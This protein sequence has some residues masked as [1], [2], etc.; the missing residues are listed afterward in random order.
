MLFSDFALPPQVLKALEQ[1]GYNE[2]TPIQA[3]ALPIVLEG[4]DLIGSAQ[5]GTGKT[6]AFVLPALA[7]LAEFKQPRPRGPR[8]LVLAPT[9][10]LA[11]QILDAT[12]KLGK[13]MRLNTV[14][15]LGGMPY[16]LQLQLLSRPVDLMVATPG[17][18]I[19][20]LERGR[21]SLADLEMLVLDEADR[22][23]DMGFVDAV[24]TIVA[25]SPATRQTLLFTA[26]FDKR[27]VQLTQ[28]ML[29]DPARVAIEAETLTVDRIEQRLHVAD[30]LGHKRR[31]LAHLAASP[32]VE[33]AIIFAATKRDADA[34]A[35]ELNAQGHQASALHGDMTQSARNYTVQKLKQGRIRLLVATDVAARGIDVKDLTHV[36]NFDLPRQAEDYVHRIGRTGRAGASGIAISFASPAD[37]QLVDRIERYTGA[38]LAPHV[39]PGLEPT[40]SFSKRSG[41]RKQGSYQNGPRR[42]GGPGGSHAGRNEGS[43][44]YR[45][46]SGGQGHYQG[47]GQ[48]SHG[49]GNHQGQGHAPAANQPGGDRPLKRAS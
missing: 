21:V 2:P 40:V 17:R 10:E 28:K 25:A 35:E 22:M 19:D 42:F 41:P 43:G 31:L 20:H 18:L 6:A 47:H 23:L 26:T 16:R 13:F 45:G 37:R 8:V 12:R 5:T 27:M 30:D 49:Q 32:E 15:I 3:Q 29:K 33:K 44:G 39:I 4:R 48:R 38:A 46:R 14:S 11:T 34:L 7:R 36:I 24:E 9:R 1:E